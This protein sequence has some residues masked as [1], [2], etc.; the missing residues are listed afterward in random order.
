MQRLVNVEQFARKYGIM[1]HVKSNQKYLGPDL[2]SSFRHRRDTFIACLGNYCTQEN[3]KHP[4]DAAT[5][6]DK[7]A[8]SSLRSGAKMFALYRVVAAARPH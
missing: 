3:T 6:S 7:G 1:V 5:P 2:K 8:G 4:A